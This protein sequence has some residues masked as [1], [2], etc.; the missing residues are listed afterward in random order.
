SV[1]FKLQAPTAT[2]LVTS[3]AA[4]APRTP[5]M[6]V[7]MYERSEAE[8]EAECEVRRQPERLELVAG[9]VVRVARLTVDFRVEAAIV[10][11]AMKVAHREVHRG[12]T[13]TEK[14]SGERLREGVRHRDLPPPN[15]R[16]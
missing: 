14:P 10:R 3:S 7:V 8:V 2:R 11:P 16:G 4:R 9:A 12:R 6:C 13:A 1:S 15:E 5:K